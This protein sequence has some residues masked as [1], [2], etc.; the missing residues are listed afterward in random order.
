MWD[1]SSEYMKRISLTRLFDMVSIISRKDDLLSHL[2]VIN[3][4]W[5]ICSGPATPRTDVH[6]DVMGWKMYRDHRSFVT[7]NQCSPLNILREGL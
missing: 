5:K 2:Y 3:F 1:I 6:D 7:E 4:R